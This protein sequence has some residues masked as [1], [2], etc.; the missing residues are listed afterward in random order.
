M[1]RLGDDALPA[2]LDHRIKAVARLAVMRAE[3]ERR[4]RTLKRLGIATTGTLQP[5]AFVNDP[6]ILIVGA[7]RGALKVQSAYSEG[8][9][10]IGAPTVNLALDI[11]EQ[12]RVDAVVIDATSDIERASETL[13]TLRRIA[14]WTRLP[15]LVLVSEDG[16]VAQMHEQGASEVLPL[17][18][19]DARL[20]SRLHLLIREHRY[21]D[22][23]QRHFREDGHIPHDPG[24][25][26]AT[27]EF[28]L[29]HL[30]ELVEGCDR[31]GDAL[32]LVAVA[33]SAQAGAEKVA[34]AFAGALARMVRGED[35]AAR[36]SD[37]LFLIMLPGTDLRVAQH[38]R[39][40]IERVVAATDFGACEDGTAVSASL[41]FS[42]Q[43]YQPGDTSDTL[44]AR[45]LEALA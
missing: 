25:P 29:A 32:S 33:V 2:E 44:L 27:R 24:C 20:V 15:A 3:V 40:R 11:L 35:L 14:T 39:E 31:N 41:R 26:L 43:S 30:I 34:S 38:V 16:P 45:T 37:G 1:D 4:A 36:V 5:P 21:G 12:N 9:R 22:A 8:P 18:C 6:V 13:A 17:E 7:G 28:A 19:E 10:F 23:I 42:L